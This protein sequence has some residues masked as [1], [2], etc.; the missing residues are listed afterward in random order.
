M[1][2]R[3]GVVV[4]AEEEEEEEEEEVVVGS[5]GGISDEFRNMLGTII[6]FPLWRNSIT[7]ANCLQTDWTDERQT[8][9]LTEGPMD[10][11]KFL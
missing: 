10:G 11:H 4:A 2:S 5:I 7:N 6:F 8:N 9:R 3:P 1:R